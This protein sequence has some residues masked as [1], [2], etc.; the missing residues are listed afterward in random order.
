MANYPVSGGVKR[1]NVKVGKDKK[2]FSRTASL[3]HRLNVN[4]RPMRGGIRL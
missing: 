4:P 1:Y 3:T 2:V